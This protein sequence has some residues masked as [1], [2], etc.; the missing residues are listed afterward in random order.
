MEERE[1][2]KAIEVIFSKE[3]RD[4]SLQYRYVDTEII[5]SLE[6]PPETLICQEPERFRFFSESV[7]LMRGVLGECRTESQRDLFFGVLR[8]TFDASSPYHP[9]VP[10]AFETFIRLNR[11]EEALH[12]AMTH[13]AVTLPFSRLLTVFSENLHYEHHRFSDELL[14]E[15]SDWIKELFTNP[16]HSAGRKLMAQRHSNRPAPASILRCLPKIRNQ[17][18]EIRFL[19]LKGKLLKGES[20]EANQDRRR[21]EELLGRLNP[22]LL[23]YLREFDEEYEK[24]EDHVDL[25]RAMGHLRTFMYQLHGRLVKGVESR[26]GIPFS[27]DSEDMEQ[28]LG[29]LKGEDVAF[30]SHGEVSLSGSLMEF[31]SMADGSRYLPKAE[32]AR[33]GKNLV[34]ETALLLLEKLEVY[35]EGP[36]P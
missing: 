16:I 13:F 15:A 32:F 1:I 19:R 8:E 18:D 28:M 11:P 12:Q 20:W 33:I 24:G 36:Q 26:S 23:S 10:L 25:G 30:F 6:K 21:I 4:D 3:S 29:Y 14:A 31:F 35:P 9:W 17:V 34:I 5:T 2:L 7:D 22:E 27:G